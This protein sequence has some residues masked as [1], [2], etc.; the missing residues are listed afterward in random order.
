MNENSRVIAERGP[1]EMIPHWLLYENTVSA[2]AIRLYLVL[3]QHADAEAKCWPSR[4]RLADLLG[5]S[6]PTVDK[7]KDQ[8]ISCGAITVEQRKGDKADWQS[9]L[10]FVY[11]NKHGVVKNLGKASKGSSIRTNTHRTYT[12]VIQERAPIE[13]EHIPSTQT[14]TSENNGIELAPHTSTRGKGGKRARFDYSAEFQHFWRVYPRRVGKRLA[15]E[16]WQAVL[17]DVD[18]DTLIH[19]AEA[20]ANDPNREQR[21]TAHP[22][23]W[24]RQGRW[25]DDPL[26][27][28]QVINATGGDKRMAHYAALH[29]KLRTRGELE[30]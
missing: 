24:L 13:Q 11:W 14:Q 16:A 4:Q 25:E 1:F 15:W 17:A 30:A 18:A 5:V 10:Y 29:N 19:S 22:T 23:T 2:L 26:P 3:R 8:L 20:Y 6:L 7:A 9:S 21:F 28:K 27:Q 12:Q